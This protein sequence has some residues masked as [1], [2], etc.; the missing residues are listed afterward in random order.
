MDELESDPGNFPH[1]IL[2]PCTIRFSSNCEITVSIPH[3][4]SKA[5]RAT[6]IGITNTARG[7]A[8]D[9]KETN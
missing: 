1:L 8:L 5:Q 7:S 2:H 3:Q 6:K 9:K 4:N